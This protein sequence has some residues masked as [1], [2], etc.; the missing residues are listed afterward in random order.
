MLVDWPSEIQWCPNIERDPAPLAGNSEHADRP[1]QHPVDQSWREIIPR[2]AVL[3][4]VVATFLLTAVTLAADSGI[5]V[6]LRIRSEKPDL[7]VI[8]TSGCPMSDW[9]DRDSA[10]LQRPGSNLVVVLQKALSGQGCLSGGSAYHAKA[11]TTWLI[12]FMPGIAAAQTA[13]TA[14]IHNAQFQ[15]RLRDFRNPV[16]WK[17]LYGVLVA[18]RGKLDID[19]DVTALPVDIAVPASKGDSALLHEDL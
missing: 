6:A 13:P 1:K 8:P 18:G 14:L 10:D 17:F 11:E 7:S 4:S 16:I 9:S 3:N 15:V 2:L 5:Q 12:P 19:L